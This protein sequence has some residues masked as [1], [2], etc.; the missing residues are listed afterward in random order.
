[1]PE[2]KKV[3]RV[4]YANRHDLLRRE[5]ERCCGVA[6]LSD[7]EFVNWLT[8]VKRPTVSKASWRFYRSAVA[9]AIRER[10]RALPAPLGLDHA[11]ERMQASSGAD[12]CSL[13]ARTS[14]LKAKRAPE[15]DILRI[16]RRLE[17]SRSP[18]AEHLR[19]YLQAGVLTGLRP[20]EW[21]G[22][23]LH[24]SDTPGYNWELIAPCAKHDAVRGIAEER[25]LRFREDLTPSLC[26]TL[27]RWILVAVQAHQQDRY[28]ALMKALSDLLYRTSRAEFPRRKQHITLYSVRHEAAARFKAAYI[29]GVEGQDTKLFG[30]AIVA[31]LLGHI[32]DLTASAHYGR[33]SSKHPAISL[34]LPAPDREQVALVRSVR[35]SDILKLLTNVPPS[36]GL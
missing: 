13:P 12:K 8:D 21:P 26:A 14:A 17:S 36:D 35:R 30:A 23:R 16:L 20:V 3:T 6:A 11:L 32:S 33:A 15:H 7:V 29:Q 19:D 2:V 28:E 34:P 24:R 5:G 31:A 18:Y 10:R 25:I 4:A 22:A 1:M 9:F 27:D